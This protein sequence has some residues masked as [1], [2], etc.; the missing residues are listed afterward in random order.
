MI[1]Q[2]S[3]VPTTGQA[4]ALAS[5]RDFLA[6]PGPGVFTLCGYAGTG[7]S[8]LVQHLVNELPGGLLSAIVVA[9]TAKAVSVLRRKG[10]P[11]AMTVHKAFYRSVRCVDPY[12]HGFE[13]ECSNKTTWIFAPPNMHNVQ[14]IVVDESSMV[15]QTH[16]RDLC[17][18]P[19]KI[20][21][22]GDKFQLPPYGGGN[23]LLT[24]NSPDAEL[25]EVCRQALD[26]PVLRLATIIREQRKLPR[27]LLEGGEF[28]PSLVSNDG[29]EF[30][31]LDYDCVPLIVRRNK[32]RHDVNSAVR[33]LLGRDSWEPKAGDRLV[34]RRNDPDAGIINGELYRVT[35][36]PL[37]TQGDWFQLAIHDDDDETGVSERS[38]RA[39]SYLFQGTAGHERFNGIDERSQRH[40]QELHYGYCITAHSSQGSEWDDVV[41]LDESSTFDDKWRWLYTSV[42][43]A[44]RRVFVLANY[45]HQLG[46]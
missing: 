35:R 30:P 42:T 44:S 26:S 24:M 15:G 2:V 10:F 13:C 20:L 1:S 31:G 36:D 21:A 33:K 32:T 38:V 23:S 40:A 9:P 8:T 22:I 18:L 11:F 12:L 7:K 29:S 17:S 4:A 25:T 14:L 39:W 41:V 34:G 6:A 43:R 37:R 28:G 19:T 27:G 5:F 16:A 46:A 3:F 45:R